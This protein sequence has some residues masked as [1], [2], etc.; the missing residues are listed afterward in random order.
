LGA[1]CEKKDILSIDCPDGDVVVHAAVLISVEESWMKPLLYHE[2]NATGALKL[3]LASV[4]RVR[5]FIY[6]NSAAVYGDP[7]RLPID[8]GHPTRPISPYEAS[9]L[10]GECYAGPDSDIDLLV[11]T[12]LA[13]SLNIMQMFGVGS[14]KIHVIYNTRASYK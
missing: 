4:R 5:R 1:R 12:K 2:V 14:K 7:V 10:A 11:V 13:G 8:E 9:K 3:L 6:I